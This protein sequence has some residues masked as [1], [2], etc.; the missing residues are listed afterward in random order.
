MEE[1]N[2]KK[3]KRKERKVE[4]G[5]L[6]QTQAPKQEV[7]SQICNTNSKTHTIPPRI[8]SPNT[9]HSSTASIYLIHTRAY[10]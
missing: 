9:Y 8:T 3:K 2:E 10:K 1:I 5:F 6:L 7:I 4:I